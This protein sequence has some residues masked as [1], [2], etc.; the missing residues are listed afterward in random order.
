MLY[1]LDEITHLRVIADEADKQNKYVCPICKEPVVLKQGSIVIPHYA[2][3]V[4]S[5][6]DD[7]N[8]MS[9]WH[10]E[11]QNR[12]PEETREVVIGNHRADVCY[13]NDVIE[14]QHSKMSA[15]EFIQR[16]IYYTGQGKTLIWIF[17]FQDENDDERIEEYAHC[18]YA[19]KYA[20]K[21]FTYFNP[22]EWKDKVFL[23]FQLD[24]YIHR[25]NWCIK[26]GYINSYKRFCVKDYVDTLTDCSMLEPDEFVEWIKRRNKG[27]A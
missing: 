23:M 14:F 16:T 20:S 24:D 15:S 9:D 21:T 11:W 2:H 3:K 7:T 26:D 19:W 1:A 6:C 25:V 4:A 8:D 22:K 12:F 17:D 27:V 5:N 10:I 13:G 18:K